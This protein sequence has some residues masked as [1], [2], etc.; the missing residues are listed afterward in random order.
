VSLFL[1]RPLAKL[2]SGTQE[3]KKVAFPGFP[4]SF[5]LISFQVNGEL[6][7]AHKGLAR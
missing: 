4:S 7:S 2:E 3:L 5:F 1:P 6:L